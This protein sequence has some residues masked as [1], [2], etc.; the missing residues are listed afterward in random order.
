[1]GKRRRLRAHR[2]HD[3][4]AEKYSKKQLHEIQ[5]TGPL[6][7]ECVWIFCGEYYIVI[8]IQF[9]VKIRYTRYNRTV[10]TLYNQL[11]IYQNHVI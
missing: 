9:N 4:E 6:S 3:K 2:A 7:G 1:M 8:D 5:I 10:Q 11:S